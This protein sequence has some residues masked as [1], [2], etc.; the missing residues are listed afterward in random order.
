MPMSE[1]DTRAKLID[2][3]LKDADWEEALITREFPYKKGRVRLIGE[4]TTKDH[5]QFVDYLLRDAPP[6]LRRPDRAA[7]RR[8]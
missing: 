2:P 3:K 8:R 5:P 7:R 4:T 1:A 6:R